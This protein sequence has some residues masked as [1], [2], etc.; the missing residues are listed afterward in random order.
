MAN[1]ADGYKSATPAAA[2]RPEELYG[3]HTA[4]DVDSQQAATGQA[5]RQHGGYSLYTPYRLPDA[6][7]SYQRGFLQVARYPTN[8]APAVRLGYY[9]DVKAAM[10]Q[11]VDIAKASDTP[12]T[13]EKFLMSLASVYGPGTI[14]DRKFGIRL[15][16]LEKGVEGMRKEKTGEKLT[17]TE[18]Q[19]T[20]A[21]VNEWSKGMLADSEH[22]T[23]VLLEDMELDSF[24]VR[25]G[26][27]ISEE[28]SGWLAQ[29]LEYQ[30]IRGIA[31]VSDDQIY[32]K[33]ITPFMGQDWEKYTSQITHVRLDA[34]PS[35]RNGEK[36]DWI[37]LGHEMDRI[38]RDRTTM[39]RMSGIL[40]A[41]APL[42]LDSAMALLQSLPA[43]Q[44]AKAA[45]KLGWAPSPAGTAAAQ[46]P[47]SSG[48]SAK[49]PKGADKPPVDPSTL[50]GG[51]C[52]YHKNARHGKDDCHFLK[53][54]KEALLAAPPPTSRPGAWGT[55]H[56]G[57][58][59]SSS[60]SFRGVQGDMPSLC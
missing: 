51:P 44:Q 24:C 6:M 43:A 12:I 50:R 22:A 31:H 2:R 7:V 17:H 30:R 16:Q 56:T 35:Q 40:A 34:S 39:R 29:C 55:E 28:P 1:W 5:L 32:A 41:P 3:G 8:A 27:A 52:P 21:A 10:K 42:T 58:C 19:I 25:N 14:E 23:D 38:A 59:F 53:T 13:A 48:T 49:A 54:A 4:M 20:L 11:W 47:A 60:T 18:A 33:F 37:L 26:R 45:K 36:W 46:P 9:R 57:P 15:T